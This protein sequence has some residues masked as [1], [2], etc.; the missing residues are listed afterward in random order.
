M[1]QLGFDVGG[2]F[3]DL[4]VADEDDRIRTL[5]VLST[6]D[7]FSRAILDGVAQMVRAEVSPMKGLHMEPT[8]GEHASKLAVAT[9]GQCDPGGA[10]IGLQ[11]EGRTARN[12]II[13]H[14]QLT[15]GETLHDL[16]GDV[17]IRRD[18]VDLVDVT[19]G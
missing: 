6:P 12:G 4:V 13:G 16:I 8:C 1:Q 9:L 3:T 5:K 11:Q 7:D 19:L 10:R 17:V 14:E 18:F 15:A 2:T